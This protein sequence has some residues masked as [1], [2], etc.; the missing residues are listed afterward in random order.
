MRWTW[1]PASARTAS[2]AARS[3]SAYASSTGTATRASSSRPVIAS[4][5]APSSAG[6]R[7]SV[8]KCSARRRGSRRARRPAATPRRRSRR[9]PRRV[10]VALGEEVADA[11][12]GQV[13]AVGAGAQELLEHR[14]LDDRVGV[15]VDRVE[16]AVERGDVVGPGPGQHVVDLDVGV[17]A[18]GD[19]AEDLHQRVVAEGHRG[20]RLLAAEQRRVGGEVDLVALE[21]VE[22]QRLAVVVLVVA[23][24]GERVAPQRHRLAVVDG[25]VGERRGRSPGRPTRRPARAPA[26]QVLAAN[27]S[28]S[29]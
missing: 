18:R 5:S 6:P 29:W 14:Q 11:G 9:P 7:C 12:L 13:P 3:P 17:H 1:S 27:S 19:P 8:G 2:N 16:P 10:Q 21:P 28:G 22:V 23:L 20:V 4:A 26:A 24:G 15:L 25:V